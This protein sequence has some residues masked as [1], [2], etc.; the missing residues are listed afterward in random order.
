MRNCSSNLTNANTCACCSAHQHLVLRPHSVHVGVIGNLDRTCTRARAHTHTHTH[1][2]SVLSGLWWFHQPCVSGIINQLVLQWKRER[3][4]E[5]RRSTVGC[6]ASPLTFPIISDL[7][8]TETSF[9]LRQLYIATNA[10]TDAPGSAVIVNF[11]CHERHQP[12]QHSLT[13]T[14]LIG[15]QKLCSKIRTILTSTF[16]PDIILIVLLFWTGSCLAYFW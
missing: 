8:K 6:K 16:T 2:K 14:V 12:L 3:R 1:I 7:Q 15:S 11:S 13:V 10:V 9:R 4:G 5:N